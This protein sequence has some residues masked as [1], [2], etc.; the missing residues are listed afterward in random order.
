VDAP[1]QEGADGQDH[2]AGCDLRAIRRDDA[3]DAHALDDE[4]GDFGFPE[5]EV[6]LRL[7]QRTHRIPVE[8]AIRLGTRRAHRRP[9]ARVQRAELDAGTVGGD[10]HRAAH[11]VDLS[12]EMALAD[13]AD[14]GVAAHLAD[15]VEAL[16]HEERARAHPRGRQGRLGAGVA[17]ADHDDVV[18]IHERPLEGRHDTQVEAASDGRPCGRATGA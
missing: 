1:A 9:L 12:H 3:G 16:C 15:R 8:R 10:C 14:R 13:P 18:V 4:V 7:Q 6:R 5:R 2:G 17:A 11:G